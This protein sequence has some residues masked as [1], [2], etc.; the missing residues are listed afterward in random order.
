MGHRTCPRVGS[1]SSKLKQKAYH[2]SAGE[3]VAAAPVA[4]Y[5]GPVVAGRLAVEVAEKLRQRYLEALVR[6]LDRY[7]AAALAEGEVAGL[8]AE[9]KGFLE[10]GML[11]GLVEKGTLDA[12][13]R[14]REE[15][16][17]VRFQSAR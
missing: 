4:D 17:R 1:S 13:I 12:L 14:A 10:A 16:L 8:K 15:A 3:R 2:R 9:L 7:F 6:K 5:S 11:S